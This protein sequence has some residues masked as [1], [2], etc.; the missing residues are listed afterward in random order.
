M[1]HF[2]TIHTAIDV[3]KVRKLVSKLLVQMNRKSGGGTKDQSQPQVDKRLPPLP[4]SLKL[5]A[6]RSASSPL[7]PPPLLHSDSPKVPPTPIDKNAM[8]ES[9]TLSSQT[10]G[11]DDR[12][13]TSSLMAASEHTY[14]R[15]PESIGPLLE[16]N[17]VAFKV[18]QPVVGK[19]DLNVDEMLDD[20]DQELGKAKL[21]GHYEV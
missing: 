12:F 20:L 15:A 13:S 19:E 3:L 9:V 21:A 2:H 4:P 7:D 11:S 10:T 18:D 5:Q 16:E 1:P 8:P 14:N 17:Q 6:T